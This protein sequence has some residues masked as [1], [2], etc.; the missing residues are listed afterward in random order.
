MKLIRLFLPL[1]VLV[2]LLIYISCRKID[3]KLDAIIN[4]NSESKFF[5]SHR[6]SDPI[7]SALVAFIK[8]ENL[9]SHFVEKTIKQLGYPYWDKTLAFIKPAIKESGRVDSEDSISIFYVPFVRDSQNFVNASLI[10]RAEQNDTTFSFVCDWQYH[11]RVHGPVTTDTTAE[12][13]ALFF[14]MLDNRTFGHTE[15]IVTDTSLFP[16]AVTTVGY[17]K[18]GIVNVYSPSSGRNN[19]VDYTL[20]CVDFYVCGDPNG[21]YY[22]VCVNSCDY[23]NCAASPG[24][25]GYCYLVNS[26]CEW[27]ETGA[28]GGGGT[29][30]TGG[31]GGAG[32]GGGGGSGPPTC[33]G[34]S[35]RT[36]DVTDPCQP[37]WEPGPTYSTEDPCIKLSPFTTDSYFKNAFTDLKDK[38]NPNA[39]NPEN[40]EYVY[41]YQADGVMVGPAAG[42]SNKCEIEQ[43]TMYMLP[44]KAYMHSHY[45]GCPEPI[46]SPGDIQLAFDLYKTNKVVYPFVFA[47]ATAQGNYVMVINDPTA[48]D[49]FGSKYF[50]EDS[51]K[52]PED[53][54]K[55]FKTYKLSLSN[56]V[57]QNEKL[58][59]DFLKGQNGTG[60]ELLK[61][62]S[63]FTQYEKLTL[64]EN[65][66]LIVTPCI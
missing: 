45:P 8:K 38:A 56:S 25:P 11:D 19:L 18:L 46:F 65:G 21:N 59:L 34:G 47:V 28:G 5:N 42:E 58:F 61:A 10:I 66:Q 3:Q 36:E 52:D 54:T 7:E 14:M 62:N 22:G 29:G 6:S 27:V 30:G 44:V 35:L 1:L 31:T 4:T 12:R 20:V 23:L 63:G 16:S 32:G 49:D 37:G 43:K 26:I 40:R 33:S 9:K 60:I 13:L 24:S 53:L 57:A 51:P 50:L 2:S 41:K 64:S 48:F 17:K 55:V 39:P 15:F